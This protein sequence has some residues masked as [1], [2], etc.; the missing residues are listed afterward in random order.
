MSSKKIAP[1][2]FYS[3][4]FNS[5]WAKLYKEIIDDLDE[6]DEQDD[7]HAKVMIN[8]LDS[9]AQ[10]LDELVYAARS[11]PKKNKKSKKSK[12]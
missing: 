1:L 10:L 3:A 6:I 7:S 5:S 9:L 2:D 4:Q 8:Y 12:K 11:Q